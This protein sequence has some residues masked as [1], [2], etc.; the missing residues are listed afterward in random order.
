MTSATRNP[1][2][3]PRVISRRI[4][5]GFGSVAVLAVA[6]CGVLISYISEVSGLVHHMRHDEAAIQESLSV[7]TSIREQY[8]HQAQWLIEKEEHHLHLYGEWLERVTKGIAALN[9]LI[10]QRKDDLAEVARMSR[11]L[12]RLFREEIRPAAERGDVDEVVR[13]H[14]S[15]SKISDEAAQSADRIAQGVERGMARV[16]DSATAVATKAM[17]VGAL[18]VTLILALAVGF[19]LRLRRSVLRPLHVVADAAK[20]FGS[21]D[22]DRRVGEVGE[23]EILE[24]ARAFD[25]MAEELHLRRQRLI[26]S[27]RMAA[28]G[29]LAAGVA[30]EINNP[31]QVIRGY[32]KTMTPDSPAATLQEEL[33]I[34]DEE[35]AACQRIAEDLVAYSRSPELSRDTVD[36]EAFLM[37]LA[38][39][40][41]E[42]PE[43]REHEVTVAA[44]PVA[45]RADPARLRQVILNLL[46][47]AAQVSEGDEPISVIGGVGADGD[48]VLRVVDR[49][50]G[51]EPEDRAKIFEPFFS[52]RAGG[53][54]LGLA[55]SHG[56]VRAH[57]GTIVA[58]AGEDGVGTCMKV[59]LPASTTERG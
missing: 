2:Q 14:K 52:K 17:V 33:Q 24:V 42:T 28:I 22:F 18:F 54:G 47:N 39:R 26:E 23:G 49:G 38:K 16:H 45:V 53:S 6:M 32:L 43:G 31:I 21:G 46:V 4:A 9:G 58:D 56:I 25:A 36:I 5:L 37:E 10:P 27:E 50:P 13:L 29:Q 20:D 8:I 34:L 30:H 1:I 55:V 11:E 12:D 44:E 40:F 51:I 19:T 15:A 3:A 57:G 35:A 41:R 48:Y 7:A 59:T